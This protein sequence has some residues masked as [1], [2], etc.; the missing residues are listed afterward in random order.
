VAVAIWLPFD[1]VACFSRPL[2]AFGAA[3]LVDREYRAGCWAPSAELSGGVAQIQQT[4]HLATRDIQ[5]R[6]ADKD[7]DGVETGENNVRG[8][9]PFVSDRRFA[10][11]GGIAG[12]VGAGKH[13]QPCVTAG[14]PRQ[15]HQLCRN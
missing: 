14:D 6:L 4:V 10:R 8:P 1:A 7:A 2:G 5:G 12:A 3:L 13:R 9:P 11:P 15:P